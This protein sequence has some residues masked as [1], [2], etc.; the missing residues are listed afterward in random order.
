MWDNNAGAYRFVIDNSG[1]VG[2]GTTNP[3]SR[4]DV[5][6]DVTVR[7]NLGLNVQYL[8]CAYGQCNS[9]VDGV[10]HV[11]ETCPSGYTVTGCT[12]QCGASN[13]VKYCGL[14]P[15]ESSCDLVCQDMNG[16]ACDIIYQVHAVCMR[17]TDIGDN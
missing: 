5:N 17:I 6:G 14:H 2:V 4:L 16:A 3:T 7:G 9:T 12:P 13:G 8:N 1:N 10:V 11:V 15:T